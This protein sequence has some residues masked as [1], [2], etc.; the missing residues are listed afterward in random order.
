MIKKTVHS[1]LILRPLRYVLLEWRR[2]CRSVKHDEIVQEV[3]REGSLSASYLFMSVMAS[4][5]ATTGLLVNSPAVIIGAML[6]S[7]LMAPIIR[8]GLSVATLE[9]LRAR[10]AALVLAWGIAMALLTAYAIVAWSPIREVTSEIASRTRPSLFD[11]MVAVLSGLAGGYAMVRGRGGAIVGVAI[12]TA[13]MPPLAVLG[14]GLASGQWQITRGAGLLFITNLVAIALSVTAVATWYGFSRRQTRHALVWQTLL[15]FFLVLPLAY[16]LSKSLREISRE[17]ALTRGIRAAV[18]QVFGSQASRVIS[19]QLRPDE[20]GG[21]M[22]ELTLAARHYT[23]ADEIGLRTAIRK[24]LDGPMDLRLSPIVEADPARASL[25]DATIASVAQLQRIPRT[26]APTP[27]EQLVA[28]FP[29]PLAGHNV[30]T[31][32][33]SIRLLLATGAPGLASCRTIEAHLQQKFPGWTITVVPPA[34]GLPEVHFASGEA[35]LDA[36]GLATSDLIQ[37]ALQAWGANSIRVY[38]HAS[39][40]GSGNARLALRRAQAVAARLTSEGR[41]V[42]TTAVVT[43]LSQRDAE[44][45]EGPG[46]F[47]TAEVVLDRSPGQVDTLSQSHLESIT[48]P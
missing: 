36:S 16:P 45:R 44:A 21:Y 25:V 47:R 34:Q 6:I 18:A 46:A 17:A 28:A 41:Q 30:D 40:E 7:P 29:F 32:K 24:L 23:Q 37:W 15:A 48:N 19:L 20:V 8:L 42:T 4:G 27:A 26:V 35:E 11:F 31:D 33:R 9:H 1:W 22:V 39:S 43:D 38:G 14:F 5:I 2:L 12:A 13:L 3:D 10:N